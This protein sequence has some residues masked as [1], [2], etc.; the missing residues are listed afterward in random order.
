M[1]MLR[2]VKVIIFFAVVSYSLSGLSFA[3]DSGIGKS[4]FKVKGCVECHITERGKMLPSTATIDD[5]IA[6]KGPELWYA[7]DKFKKGFLKGWLQSPTPIRPMEYYSSSVENRGDHPILSENEASDIAAYLMTLRSGKVKRGVIIPKATINGRVI[8]EKRLGCYGC[9]L[10]QK[11]DGSIV[12]GL[13]G[14]TLV[15]AGD[16]L[17]ADWIYSYLNDQKFF[18]HLFIMPISKGLISDAKMHILAAHIA[19]MP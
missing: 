15:G 4:L 11:K 5:L 19:A 14:P 17:S 13:S 2:A 10:M 18:Q 8:F 1:D 16:R 3:A 9:H 6:A 12:G 7:G